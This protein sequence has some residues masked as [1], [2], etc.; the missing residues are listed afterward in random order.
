M[1]SI[2]IT[3]LYPRIPALNRSESVGNVISLKRVGDYVYL[4]R[5]AM[6]YYLW[7][8]LRRAKGWYSTE[9]TNEGGTIQFDLSKIQQVDQAKE[10]LSFGFMVTSSKDKKDNTSSK[11]K[12]GNITRK[13]AV[14]MTEGEFMN[15]FLGEISFN[16]NHD[17]VNRLKKEKEADPN[18][19]NR[20]EHRGPMRWSLVIDVDRLKTIESG[21]KTNF[22]EEDLKRVAG[23]IV[24]DILEVVQNGL[25]YHSNGVN[26]GLVPVACFVYTV[27]APIPVLHTVSRIRMVDEKYY[28]NFEEILKFRSNNLHISDLL[29]T[30]N[31]G[32]LTEDSKSELEELKRLK[33]L[34]K[35]TIRVQIDFSKDR[36]Q[37]L[38]E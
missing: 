13:A 24:N 26:I 14:S 30:V 36:I 38:E 3:V 20:E 4:S 7:E 10:L 15:R 1:K 12:K 31:E 19:Y 23:Q 18:P 29:L 6:R 33:M 17:F 37:L 16:A 22:S 21:W 27:A 11:D 8:T 35:K 28:I 25:V 5:Q 32:Q 9:V 34:A 2:G